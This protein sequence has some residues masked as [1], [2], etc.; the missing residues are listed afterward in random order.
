[1]TL[2]QIYL[3]SQIVAA[4]AVVISL[5]FVGHQIKQNTDSLRLNTAAAHIAAHHQAIEQV[6]DA[7]MQ[8]DFAALL[9]KALGTPE[10]LN[11]HEQLRLDILL[12]ADLFG[13]EIALHL[14]DHGHIDA[15][16]WSNM[17]ANNRPQLMGPRHQA[18][19]ALRPGPLSARLRAVLAAHGT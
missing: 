13:H 18:L 14:A 3:V 9:L 5:V 7:W 16:L 10:A 6:K 17:L 8:P 19:L 2:E 4:F 11:E 12:S 15:D 1:M